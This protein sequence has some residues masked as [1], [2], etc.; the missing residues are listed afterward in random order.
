[1]RI[2]VN[3]QHLMGNFSL[4]QP[5][6]GKQ[7]QSFRELACHSARTLEVTQPRR[8]L[9]SGS[10]LGR[11][12][13]QLSNALRLLH[14]PPQFARFL[15]AAPEMPHKALSVLFPAA[16]PPSCL[17]LDRKLR[18]NDRRVGFLLGC[19]GGKGVTERYERGRE[20]TII[21]GR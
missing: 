11:S 19:R 20:A 4:S 9:S 16:P 21:R 14:P 3:R 13:G 12:G 18:Q 2:D 5:S 7:K 6:S 1:M 8:L 10:Y 17:G 15:S